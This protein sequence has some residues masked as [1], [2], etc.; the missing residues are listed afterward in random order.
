MYKAMT[1][2]GPVQRDGLGITNI[3]EHLVCCPPSPQKER[4]PDLILDS[5]DRAAQELSWFAMAGGRTLVEWST[6][7]YGR[8]AAT[9]HRLSRKTGVQVIAT[10]GYLRGEYAGRLVAR[11]SLNQLVDLI[12]RE[13]SEGIE[14]TKVRAGVIKAGSGLDSIDAVEE[15]ALRAAAR[16]QRETGAPLGTHTSGGTMGVAQLRILLQEGAKSE[17]ILIGHLDRKLDLDYHME[18]ARKGAF[19]GYDNI[20]KEEF[21]QDSQRIALIKQLILNGFG[22]QVLLGC[23]LARKSYWPSYGGGPGFTYL[24]WRFVPWMRREGISAEAIEKQ[25]V[26]NPARFLCFIP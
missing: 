7:D 26:L 2:T 3:H 24:L 10:T 13:I 9:L 14:G 1:V 4:D 17:R 20:S 11:K 6:V 19:L 16:A 5:E 12:V 8:D 18:I 23:D 21:G 22:D 25:L 15:K